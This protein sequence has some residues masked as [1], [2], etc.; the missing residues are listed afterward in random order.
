VSAFKA[1]LESEGELAW[2]ALAGALAGEG[3]P[4]LEFEADVW[5]RGRLR[6]A[7]ALPGDPITDC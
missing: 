2:D 4:A 3:E 6:S 5:R 1:E 7:A